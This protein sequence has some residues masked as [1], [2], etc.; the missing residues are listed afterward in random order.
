MLLT[1]A[2][3]VYDYLFIYK[4][5][6]SAKVAI[7]VVFNLVSL[8]FVTICFDYVRCAAEMLDEFASIVLRMRILCGT[9]C[10]LVLG[11]LVYEIIYETSKDTAGALC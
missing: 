9:G 3:V 5:Q 7:L 2:L 6:L 10:A 4:S 1:Q 11:A 8:L